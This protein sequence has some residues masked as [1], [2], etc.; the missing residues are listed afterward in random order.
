M[1]DL[2]NAWNC[3]ISNKEMPNFT[4]IDEFMNK[5]MLCRHTLA[6]L[7]FSAKKSRWTWH[8]I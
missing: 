2:A 3:S 8:R 1:I 5:A 4:Q 6:L 7:L